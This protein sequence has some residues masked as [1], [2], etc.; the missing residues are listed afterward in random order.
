MP[1]IAYDTRKMY[2][3]R[4]RLCLIGFGA[5][6]C[7]IWHILTR[8]AGINAWPFSRVE[9]LASR[10]RLHLMRARTKVVGAV[11]VSV[12]AGGLVFFFVPLV[13]VEAVPPNWQY[14]TT[15]TAVQGR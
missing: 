15:V 5:W 2:V 14:Y 8:R 4:W 6:A 13:G 12:L 10:P 1:T 7:L 9:L 11:A 3:V